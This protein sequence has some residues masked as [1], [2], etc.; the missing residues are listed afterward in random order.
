MCRRRL[1]FHLT[2][3][4]LV[5]ELHI[6]LIS[7]LCHLIKSRLLANIEPKDRAVVIELDAGIV[8]IPIVEVYNYKTGLAES[9]KLKEGVYPKNIVGFYEPQPITCSHIQ[10]REYSTSAIEVHT[11]ANKAE[12]CISR[13]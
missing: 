7:M 10:N 12:K 5:R 9:S 4:P 2:I 1:S 8:L 11:W 13:E 3:L 6:Y